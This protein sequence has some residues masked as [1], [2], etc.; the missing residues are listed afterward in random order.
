MIQLWAAILLIGSLGHKDRERVTADLIKD[1][2]VGYH[3]ILLT[4][5]S[6]KDDPEVYSRL[7]EVAFHKW[8]VETHE[9]YY[10]EDYYEPQGKLHSKLQLENFN[11]S[12]GD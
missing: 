12:W 3:M 5:D 6:V 9:K 2:S 8:C 10:I 1:P 7:K 11:M 4:K